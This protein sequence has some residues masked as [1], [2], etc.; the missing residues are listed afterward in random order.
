MTLDYIIQIT[1][2]SV[3]FVASVIILTMIMRAGLITPYR[4]IIFGLSAG[5]AIASLGMITGPFAPPKGLLLSPLGQG[6]TFTCDANGFIILFGGTIVTAY[7]LFLSVYLYFKLNRKMSQP[8]FS[9]KIEKKMHIMIILYAIG[10]STAA[11]ATH[12]INPIRTG[13]ICY[14]A[15]YP[16]GCGI[17]PEIVGEC[18]RG[19]ASNYFYLGKIVD[20]LC[21]VLITILIIL[22]INNAYY[23]ENIYRLDP[24]DQTQSKPSCKNCITGI[25]CFQLEQKQ[26]EEESHA[27][28]LL[29]LYRR[30]T[31]VQGLLYIGSFFLAHVMSAVMTVLYLMA[32]DIPKVIILF[33]SLLFPLMGFF[34]ILVYCRPKVKMHQLTHPDSSLLWSFILVVKAGGEVPVVEEHSPNPRVEEHSPNPE[35]LSFLQTLTMLDSSW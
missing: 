23:L 27:D 10:T 22:V 32:M 13:A 28:F 16:P 11:L 33:V 29:R 8:I 5:D 19:L 7:L 26:R 2:A 1:S 34:N 35:G 18:S 12:S 9:Q 25:F 21:L 17:I 20:F 6:N 30:E 15:R 14:I 3:S 24:D 31:I 4:R